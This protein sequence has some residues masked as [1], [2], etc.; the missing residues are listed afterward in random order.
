MKALLILAML[1]GTVAAADCPSCVKRQRMTLRHNVVIT[2]LKQV[3]RKVERKVTV[4][5]SPAQQL[6]E[7]EAEYMARTGRVG[8]FMAKGQALI[9]VGARFA[10]TGMATVGRAVPTCKPRSNRRPIADA[11]VCRRGRCYRCR[12]W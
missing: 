5:K 8:H 11:T 9:R 6:A 4:T 3:E 7:R 2:P 1:A 10:G 12:L